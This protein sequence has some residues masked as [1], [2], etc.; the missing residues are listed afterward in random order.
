MR[1]GKARENTLQTNLFS[2]FLSFLHFFGM[3]CVF[4]CMLLVCYAYLLFE[5]PFVS[6]C[7]IHFLL[8]SFFLCCVSQHSVNLSTRFTKI[9][10]SLNMPQFHIYIKMNGGKKWFLHEHSC[11]IKKVLFYYRNQRKKCAESEKNA[12]WWRKQQQQNKKVTTAT[13]TTWICA[14]KN[15]EQD[16]TK[17][18]WS[19]NNDIYSDEQ[20]SETEEPTR[21]RENR[22][23][24]TFW[25]ETKQSYTKTRHQKQ[26][27]K[28]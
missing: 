11:R 19:K 17:K 6:S 7:L 8:I 14:Y 24:R 1:K 10:N 26:P 21:Q 5:F 23:K 28:K 27:K 2:V 15:V 16:S 3:P 22:K 4:L 13:A 20:T 12:K 18:K 25:T 9:Q